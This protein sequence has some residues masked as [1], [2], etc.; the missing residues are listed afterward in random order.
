VRLTLV[1]AFRITAFAEAASFIALLGAT[2][3]KYAHDEAAGVQVL[4]PLHG[5]L[6]IAYVLMA[7]NLAPRAGWSTKTTVWVLAAAVI[8]FGGFVVDRW[9][10]R[11]PPVL[12]A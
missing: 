2:Y 10:A 6:F 9:L 7:L 4:G 1:Q 8:P 3:V 5:L 11:T 12:S